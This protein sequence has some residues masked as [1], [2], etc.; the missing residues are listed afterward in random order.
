M[1][2]KSFNSPR[3]GVATRGGQCRS[4]AGVCPRGGASCAWGRPSS[5]EALRPT[6]ALWLC[7]AAGGAGRWPRG[8]R[9]PLWQRGWQRGLSATAVPFRNHAA[10]A[11]GATRGAVGAV[12]VGAGETTVHGNLLHGN[13]EQAAAIV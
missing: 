3:Q 12:A 8:L 10:V 11:E 5:A 4:V 1:E 2:K 7:R 9:I 13:T 6:V